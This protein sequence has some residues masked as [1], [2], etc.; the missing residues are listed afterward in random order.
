MNSVDELDSVKLFDCMTSRLR[1][2]VRSLFFFFFVVSHFIVVVAVDSDG[3]VCFSSRDAYSQYH[4]SSQLFLFEGMD[5]LESVVE[6]VQPTKR[7]QSA[8]SISSVDSDPLDFREQRCGSRASSVHGSDSDCDFD[9]VASVKSEGAASYT[10]AGGTRRFHAVEAVDIADLEKLDQ[11]LE[12]LCNEVLRVETEVSEAPVA[13]VDSII[14]SSSTVV[15]TKRDDTL[16]LD[17]GTVMCL[18]DGK[19]VGVISTLLGP[20]ATCLYAIVCDPGVIAALE[21]DSLLQEGT[22]MHYSLKSQKILFDPIASCD[23]NPPTDAS[24]LQDE[25]LPQTARPDFSDD[26]EERNWKKR[27]RVERTTSVVASKVQPSDDLVSSSEESEVE[28]DDEGN[29]LKYRPRKTSDRRAAP[30]RRLETI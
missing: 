27:R 23:P 26:D 12:K 10:T 29:I 17:V 18:A 2:E 4:T 6:D 3:N 16:I 14:L 19:V 22:P 28:F 20:V 25:E 15:A 1:F 8:G 24:F 7:A 11:P 13:F 5:L 30:S 9:D 21:M